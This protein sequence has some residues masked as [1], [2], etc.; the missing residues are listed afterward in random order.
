M[1][2]DFLYEVLPACKITM[3]REEEMESVINKIN[4]IIDEYDSI[5][6]QVDLDGYKNILIASFSDYPKLGLRWHR[7]IGELDMFRPKDMKYPIFITGG[8]S[9]GDPPTD[10]YDSFQRLAACRPIWNKLRKW[11][12]EDRA[13][14]ESKAKRKL[15]K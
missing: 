14:Q 6:P 5:D 13:K 9:W 2:A 3:D 12:I 1:G 4:D 11:A 8:M 10:S 15:D 7:D